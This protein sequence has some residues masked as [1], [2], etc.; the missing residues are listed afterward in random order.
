MRRLVH[1]RKKLAR[2][3]VALYDPARRTRPWWIAGWTI[4]LALAAAVVAFGLWR[5]LA[6]FESPIPGVDDPVS[7]LLWFTVSFIAAWLP[8]VACGLRARAL[9]KR[10]ESSVVP[11]P[12][13]AL[14]VFDVTVVRSLVRHE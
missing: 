11:D 5:A 8:L 4:S 10:I 12:D 9:R 2:D 13:P 7:F 6:R 3:L 1:V 14:L